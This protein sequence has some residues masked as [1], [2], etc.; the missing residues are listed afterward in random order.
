[1]SRINLLDS[2]IYNK[3]SAGE[4]VERPSSVVKELTENSIDAGASQIIIEIISGGLR[5][6]SVSDNGIGMDGKDLSLAFMPHATSK[7]SKAEDL[8]SISTL[9][10]RGEALSS[11]ASVS[12]LSVKSKTKEMMSGNM[13]EIKAGEIVS[14]TPCSSN[15]GTIIRVE[16]LFFNTPARLSFMRRP[17]YEENETKSIVSNLILANPSISFELI[18]D[19]KKVLHSSGQGLESAIEGVYDREI[20]ENLIPLNYIKGN[21][22][23]KGF[24][25]K[26][27]FS[28]SNRS[29][30]SIII[31]GRVITCQTISAAAL[32][33]YGDSMMKRCYPVFIIDITMPF[34]MVDVNVHPS[35]AEVRFKDN[36]AIYGIIYSSVSRTLNDND[37]VIPE[38]N[39]AEELVE[40]DD[41]LSEEVVSDRADDSAIKYSTIKKPLINNT[42]RFINLITENKKQVSES[43]G[44]SAEIIDNILRREK[45]KSSFTQE[46]I[47]IHNDEY[48]I[49]GQLFNTYLLIQYGGDAFIIDQH[50]AMERI[51][52]DQLISSFQSGH[53][54]QPLLVPHVFNANHYES[55]FLDDNL[56][57]FREIGIEIEPFGNNCYKVSTV[58]A[59]I[60]DINLDSFLKSAI[61]ELVNL[62]PVRLTEIIKEKLSQIACKASI[63]GGDVLTTDQIQLLLNNIKDG[64]IP[65][66]CPHGRPAIIRLTR[67][68]LDKWFK[69]IK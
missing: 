37:M 56:N 8:F 59:V 18:A 16:N 33:A 54:K 32:K 65:L 42:S 68:E 55:S 64:K 11:I 25:G 10:F 39:I 66:Q 17:K 31:N 47:A 21:Y 35:K 60:S 62:N 44:I 4:V 51:N 40:K 50:A 30:Q 48:T 63:K 53:F 52:Y 3:I 12:M 29:Y 58:P 57:A 46:K 19:G 6:I 15:T 23:V 28:K 24:I 27:N 41:E 67:D 9:G 7:L 14:N 34:D 2:S 61:G 36:N 5:S 49:I 26:R 13:L 1:M 20:C 38:I 22:K 45:E 69:R 43:Q